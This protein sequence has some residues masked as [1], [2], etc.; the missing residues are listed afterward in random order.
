MEKRKS[1]LVASIVIT[2][3]VMGL[4]AFLFLYLSNPES[5]GINF[6]VALGYLL[7]I[8]LI[9]GIYLMLIYTSGSEL[10]TKGMWDY[11][12]IL[13]LIIFSYAVVGLITI[14]AFAIFNLIVT[15]KKILI[16]AVVVET[17]L[18]IIIGA[19]AYFLK[20]RSSSFE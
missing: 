15:T 17:G 6:Y 9:T 5:R 12:F 10:R 20:A 16:T 2:A 19:L 14:I 13:G 1:G 8:E 11:F 18:F 3:I 7:F 4:T